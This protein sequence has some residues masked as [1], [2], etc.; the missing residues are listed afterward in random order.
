M[1]LKLYFMDALTTSADESKALTKITDHF[2]KCGVVYLSRIPT[3]MNVTNVRSYLDEFGEIGRLYLVPENKVEG[4]SDDQKKTFKYVEGW[5][6]FKNKN[7]AKRCAKFLNNQQ[8][9]GFNRKSPWY[10]DLWNI[11]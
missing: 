2:K 6:E 3:K 8:V 4:T 10:F 1:Q 11:K 5:V 9:S 7:D